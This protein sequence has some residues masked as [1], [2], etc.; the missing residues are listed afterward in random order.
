MEVGRS[1]QANPYLER[2]VKKDDLC[3]MFVMAFL[4]NMLETLYSKECVHSFCSLLVVNLRFGECV[5]CPGRSLLYC[6]HRMKIRVVLLYIE[7]IFWSVSS[8]I[9]RYIKSYYTNMFQVKKMF[10]HSG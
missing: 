4:G 10:H 5:Y 2:L 9:F 7:L 3:R 6:H 8:L 1:A